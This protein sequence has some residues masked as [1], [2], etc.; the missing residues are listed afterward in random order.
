MRQS[1]YSPQLSA[2]VVHALYHEGQRRRMPMTR[3]ADELLRQAL[4]LRD[5]GKQHPSPGKQALAPATEADAA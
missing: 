4:G 5:W 2:D 1:P 3:L